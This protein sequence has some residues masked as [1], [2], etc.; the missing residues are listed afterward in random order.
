MVAR[1]NVLAIDRAHAENDQ[2][3]THSRESRQ[4]YE[5]LNSLRIVLEQKD[6]YLGKLQR[7][8]ADSQRALA[9]IHE[10][11]DALTTN[12]QLKPLLRALLRAVVESLGL[13]VGA[14]LTFDASREHLCVQAVSVGRPYAEWSHPCELTE[15]V[16]SPESALANQVAAL[17]IPL[18]TRSADGVLH[19]SESVLAAYRVRAVL[20]V[21]LHG[22]NEVIG[23][24]EFG[25]QMPRRFTP[26]EVKLAEAMAER[27]A[28]AIEN[29]ALRHE[30]RLKDEKVSSL[31]RTTIDAQEAER[32]RICLDIHDGV[33]QTLAAA[34]Q[35]QQLLE[36]HGELRG[37][38]AR[39][40]ISQVGALIQRA[41][42]ETR[43]VIST[44]RPACLDAA[45]LVPTLRTDLENL[46]LQ[47][48]WQVRFE[49]DP[50]H[51][52]KPV[53]TALYR[54]VNEAVNNA[55][56]HSQTDR[57]DVCL[58]RESGKITVEVRDYGVGFD[59][60][61]L[62]P[63]APGK[64]VGLLSMRRRAELLQG[65]CEVQSAPG[66]GTTVRIEMPSASQEDQ[67]G[68]SSS[69]VGLVELF[70]RPSRHPIG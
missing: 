30:L 44:A 5:T 56:K 60:A 26:M 21:P 48:G 68:R 39:R 9:A 28:S 61:Q 8:L 52:P 50:V 24:A 65:H 14:V 2:V 25:A 34:F 45:G 20:A 64:R 15:D 43:E 54:I 32:E 22:R 10:M 29:S 51:L 57:L 70:R 67:P 63:G 66:F 35:Y 3:L 12:S 7:D 33:A 36:A 1:S 41:I 40:L 47:L 49:A 38:G 31:L 19:S 55:R 62:Q 69:P 13:R 4:L 18:T 59:P 6:Q 37:A 27:A 46:R 23:V 11:T 16:P 17:G 42:Q 58:R 53:E